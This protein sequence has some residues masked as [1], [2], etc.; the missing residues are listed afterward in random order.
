[1]KTHTYLQLFARKHN[2]S[3]F[4]YAVQYISPL[5][6][7]SC[8]LL[9]P[10]VTGVISWAAGLEGVPPASTWIGGVVVMLGVGTISA[11]ERGREVEVGDN[12]KLGGVNIGDAD[13]HVDTDIGGLDSSVLTLY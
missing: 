4:N 6:F 3:G 10:A 9:D 7:A 1:M 5:V 13:G 12:D 8:Q 2:T 11:G